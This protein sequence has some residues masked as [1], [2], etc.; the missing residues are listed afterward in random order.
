MIKSLMRSDDYIAAIAVA[1]Y[2]NIVNWNLL[3]KHDTNGIL[4]KFIDKDIIK[5]KLGSYIR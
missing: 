1:E 5:K 3:Y 4:L 2:I